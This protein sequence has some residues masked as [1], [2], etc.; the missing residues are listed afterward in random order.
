MIKLRATRKE[1]EETIAVALFMGGGPA[2]VY[3]GKAL[4]AFDEL[5]EKSRLSM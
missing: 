2:T 1:I 3:G 4:E 5:A